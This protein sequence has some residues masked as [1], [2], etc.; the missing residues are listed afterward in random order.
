[1]ENYIKKINDKVLEK[2]SIE[3]A[4][5]TKARFL[6]AGGTTLGLGL[7]GFVSSFIT[8][9]VLF[10]SYETDRAFIAWL[11]AIPFILM[12]IAGSVV[13]RIGD[14]L[15]KVEGVTDNSNSTSS[16][17]KK[18]KK[19]KSK[20]QVVEDKDNESS[21]IISENSQDELKEN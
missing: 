1:M 21:E 4:K 14:M 9:F 16:K 11:V 15:L 10:L 5:K 3:E 8:F 18:E 17:D 6:I 2:N 13:T 19:P 20:K 12:I 7:A